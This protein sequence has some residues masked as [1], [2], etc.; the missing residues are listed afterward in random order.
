MGRGR[1]GRGRRGRGGGDLFG[2]EG[3]RVVLVLNV[4]AMVHEV[5]IAGD[6]LGFWYYDR[7]YGMFLLT[8]WWFL[9]VHGLVKIVEIPRVAFLFIPGHAD[10]EKYTQP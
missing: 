2:G 8:C 7:G 5:L 6:V 9:F 10:I 1:F 3:D 4:L